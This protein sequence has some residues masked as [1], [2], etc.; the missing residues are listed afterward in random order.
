MGFGGLQHGVGGRPLLHTMTA[1][2]GCFWRI[3]G[4]KADFLMLVLS[5]CAYRL[6]PR[7]ISAAMAANRHW[8][9]WVAF[10]CLQFSSFGDDCFAAAKSAIDS[11][12]LIKG[13]I[14][15]W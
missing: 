15:L 4:F 8:I 7:A 12:K 5:C 2:K 14:R 6:D 13:S 11:T 9:S 3:N 10:G 1:S